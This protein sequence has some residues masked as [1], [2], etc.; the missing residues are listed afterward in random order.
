[1]GEGEFQAIK[2]TGFVVA[3]L[4]VLGLQRMSPHSRAGGSRRVNLGLWGVNL[5]VMGGVCGA[6][7]CAASL[8]ASRHEFGLLNAIAT[9]PWVAVLATVIGL[10]F[11]SYGW[12]RLNHAVPLL[13]RFH[14]VHHGDGLFTASTGVRFHP[15]E[16]LLSLPLRLAAVLLMGAPVVGVLGFELSFGI[17]NLF[18]HGDI[19]LPLPLERSLEHVLVTPALHR[20]HHGR[21]AQQHGTN[22]GTIFS[23]WDRVLATFGASSS[24]SS[25]AIGLDGVPRSLS[26]R[27]VLRLPFSASRARVSG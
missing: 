2:S 24:V 8:W 7:A 9:P 1:M 13:W 19:D 18:V 15:G 5:V 22:F 21:S 14:Q 26:F 6:C 12:H 3:V 25:I 11:V 23:W 17:A 4:L 16:L 10:D 20:R 27:G